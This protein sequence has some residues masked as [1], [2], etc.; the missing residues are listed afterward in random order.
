MGLILNTVIIS[1]FYWIITRQATVWDTAYLLGP[2]AHEV[3]YFLT[4]ILLIIAIPSYLLSI[5]L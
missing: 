4:V 3:F 5:C 2:I 1:L